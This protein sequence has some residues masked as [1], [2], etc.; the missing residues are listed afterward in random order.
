MH[1]KRRNTRRLRIWLRGLDN[2]CESSTMFVSAIVNC[3]MG[4]VQL[5]AAIALGFGVARCVFR[6]RKSLEYNPFG[7]LLDAIDERDSSSGQANDKAKSSAGIFVDLPEPALDQPWMTLT[8]KASYASSHKLA[9][10]RK[11]A[12]RRFHC[13]AAETVCSNAMLQPEFR[14]P[15]HS[16]CNGLLRLLTQH[17]VG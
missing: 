16:R 13:A 11:Q 2:E 5:Q 8:M 9:Q 12:C 15:G 17:I 3:G 14:A 6:A 1:M 10:A 7:D 4:F